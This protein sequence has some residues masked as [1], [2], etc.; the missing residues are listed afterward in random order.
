MTV[1]AGRAQLTAEVSAWFVTP[2]AM[3]L[4]YF[5]FSAAAAVR[6]RIFDIAADYAAGLAAA[7]LLLAVTLF[8]PVPQAHRKALLLL[9]LIRTGVALGP[10]LAYDMRYGLD[11]AMYFITGKAL[12]QPLDSL[13]FG[14][15]TQNVRA[16]VGLLSHVTESYN[17]MKVIFSYVGL[18]AVYLFYRAAVICLG[19]ERIA[20]LYILGLFPSF[21]VWTSIL[22]KDP[23]V[24]LGIGLYCYGAAGVIMRHKMS[25][26]VYVALGLLIASFIRVWLGVIF[27][28]PLIGAYVL[29][30]RSSTMTKIAF[31]LVA[32][33][34]FLFAATGFSDRF[35]LETT[36]DLIQRTDTIS[37]S[38]ARGGSAQVIQGGF[39][40]VGAMVAFLP[41][42]SFT[43]LF[44]P[45]PFEVP[46][47]F[48]ALAGV[49][50]LTILALFLA[51][52]LRK[53]L[54]WITHPVLMWAVLVLLIWGSVYGFASY[55]NLGTAFRFRAQV[56]PIL[57]LLSLY[58]CFG[59]YLAPIPG[60]RGG[61]GRRAG[62]AP[63]ANAS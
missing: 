30:G 11:A 13:A 25:M 53:G 15:G 10:M 9:W 19:Q 39:S 52:L 44:R 40:S 20:L 27:I 7:L 1:R 26:L 45:L 5:Y 56:A 62:L 34:A 12:S 35:N 48:G 16:I 21:L 58:L 49:E 29:A 32:L 3:V 17:A 31:V 6:F 41:V 33:P 42:G 43:A 18:I 57:L 54:R 38:W 46:N 55:Q 8:W 37:G 63:D 50:N 22:G 2:V 14:A 4:G 60:A 51:G 36:E 59:Q 61:R 24:S 47:A 28:A 23:I